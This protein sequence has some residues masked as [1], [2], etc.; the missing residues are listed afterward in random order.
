[1]FSV[2]IRVLVTQVCPLCENVMDYALFV[3]ISHFQ[4]KLRKE[5]ER[6]AVLPRKARTRLRLRLT[7]AVSAGR[8]ALPACAQSRHLTAPPT[9]RPSPGIL[10]VRFPGVEDTE[11]TCPT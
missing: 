4:E 1:M 5:R 2:L 3:G 7:S 6:E 11:R 9:S 8:G 10:S